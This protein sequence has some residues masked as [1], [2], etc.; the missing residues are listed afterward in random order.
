MVPSSNAMQS[1]LRCACL[2][3]SAARFDWKNPTIA[4]MS[5]P[6]AWLPGRATKIRKTAPSEQKKRAEKS[7]TTHD[8]STLTAYGANLMINPTP[9]AA[10]NTKPNQPIRNVERATMASIYHVTILS[11]LESISA[12]SWFTWSKSSPLLTASIFGLGVMSN[13]C[14]GAHKLPFS[15][16][17]KR[18]PQPHKRLIL[19]KHTSRIHTILMLPY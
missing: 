4:T 18:T 11:E 14:L 9:T 3:I 17:N 2:F 19:L 15:S 7:T 16:E 13:T 10:A 12:S 5:T 1:N 8:L 6:M